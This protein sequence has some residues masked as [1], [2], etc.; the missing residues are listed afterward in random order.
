[1]LYN[2]DFSCP[3]A[4]LVLIPQNGRQ[5]PR[6]W[7]E[8]SAERQ[9]P[10]TRA[11]TTQPLENSTHGLG[12]RLF[13]GYITNPLLY[14]HLIKVHFV[15]DNYQSMICLLYKKRNQVTPSY[16]GKH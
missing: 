2:V 7:T 6:S 13:S 14:M 11:E 4:N 9:G 10:G 5:K 3:R 8:A 15:K 1:M 16:K 12:L